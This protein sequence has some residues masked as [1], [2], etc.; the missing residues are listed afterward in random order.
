V[1]KPQENRK[2]PCSKLS[3]KSK[4]K[5]RAEKDVWNFEGVNKIYEALTFDNLYDIFIVLGVELGLRPQEIYGLKWNRLFDDY[6][7][8][9]EAIIK[10]EQGEFELG[11]TKT[12]TSKRY[13]PLIP[14]VQNKLDL[15]RFKQRERMAKCKDNVVNNLVVADR[16]GNDPCQRYVGRYIKSKAKS[17]GIS[18]IPPKEAANYVG[19]VNERPW[20]ATHYF[21]TRGWP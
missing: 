3:I 10:R 5:E 12:N 6:V 8:I 7:A 17:V 18:P 9:E 11:T 19:L 2:N 4:P 20:S 16:K 13:L 15:H 1:C 21:S 14:F